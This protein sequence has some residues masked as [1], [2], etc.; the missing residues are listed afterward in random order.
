[1]CVCVCVCVCV[2]KTVCIAHNNQ[3]SL[4]AM[5]RQLILA[6]V[7]EGNRRSGRRRA[8]A[9]A[10]HGHSA[11]GSRHAAGRRRRRPLERVQRRLRQRTGPAR[12]HTAARLTGEML[13]GCGPL[14]HL[15]HVPWSLSLS[16]YCAPTSGATRN[17]GPAPGQISQSSPPF[18]FPT[19]PFSSHF[20]LLLHVLPTLLFL[21]LPI[22][23]PFLPLSLCLQ[24]I[25]TA[26]WAAGRASGL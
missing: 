6:A 25:D 20:P 22:P 1:V 4:C 18:P 3:E 16:V 26:G 17:S 19:L 23:N 11:V 2:S 9:G 24:C 5:R 12:V 15:L 10:R 14:L 7:W 8:Y 13:V 21:P